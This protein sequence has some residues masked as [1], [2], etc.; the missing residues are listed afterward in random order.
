MAER[1]QRIFA[2][3][4]GVGLLLGPA[5]FAAMLALPAPEALDV[6]GQRVAAVALFMAIWWVSEAVP[7]PVTALLPILLFPLLGV[8]SIAA[9]SAPYANP[10]I[11]LFLGGFLI[12]LGVQ[13]WNLHRRLALL[14]LLR[15]GTS[16][17]R[18]VAGFML[19][20]AALS[21]WISNTATAAMMLPVG[22][23]LIHLAESSSG[24]PA[25]EPGATRNFASAL[26]LGIA[27]AATAG[28]LAT[29]IGTPP[30]ALLAA[31]LNERFGLTVGFAQWM[32]VGIPVTLILL[33][34][35][36]LLLTRFVYPVGTEPIAGGRTLIVRE[37]AA[38]GPM[39]GPEKRVAAVFALTATLWVLRP[40]VNEWLPGLALS[41]PAVAL[42]GGLLLF[43]LPAEKLRNGVFLLDW[44]WASRL[45]WRVLLLF[46][47]GLSLADAIDSS[48]LAHWIG[49][50][51]THLAGAPP[52]LI[53]LA[54]A[55]VI[56]F[57]TELTSNTAT[58]ATFLPVVGLLAISAG[59]NPL[60]LAA[61][62]AL[63]ASC[64]YMLPVATPPNAIVFGSGHITIP[65]MVRAGIW[66]N[67]LSILV[68]GLLVPTLAHA[69]F[70][71]PSGP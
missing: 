22:L 11:F 39:T 62:A 25:K 6:S 57:L 50:G 70:G 53:A 51:L 37:L 29:L 20:T 48:G 31:Y 47:G 35:I 12:A 66:L 32:L 5:V 23:S 44:E 34:A 30:N 14:I 58:A 33:P 55:T 42:L 61:V 1:V 64:A 69:V 68:V 27:Y 59:E 9:A 60:A 45:P 40:F 4:R 26:L 46:G 19:A 2:Q 56:V 65:Q 13:R 36:W 28:G 10:L 63:A 7:V 41:D 18:I 38:L 71:D 3:V 43:V 54:V 8:S 15:V 21:M 67:V 24:A 49:A 52:L 16:P 17:A